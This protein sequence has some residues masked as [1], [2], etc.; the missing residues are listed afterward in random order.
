M[1]LKTMTEHEYRTHPALNQ[2][3]FKDF[4]TKTPKQFAHQQK[5]EVK[6]K[7]KITDAMIL[8]SLTDCLYLE[9]HLLHREFVEIKTVTNDK[10]KTSPAPKTAN[11]SPDTQ[12][13]LRELEAKGLRG[14]LANHKEEA[15][16]IVNA[17]PQA[18]LPA[19]E[20]R[21]IVGIGTICGVPCKG[22]A[23]WIDDDGYL[24]DLK[25]TA[26]FSEFYYKAKAPNSRSYLGYDIQAAWYYTLFKELKP[27]G[28]RWLVVESKEPYDYKIYE[29]SNETLTD[30]QYRIM[31]ALEEYKQCLHENEWPGYDKTPEV[32]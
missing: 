5:P 25:T 26:A 1:A 27:K 16:K 17:L 15:E 10:G 6:A 29:A 28:F 4:I 7:K 21:Q 19:P 20:Q 3:T 30:A 11:N 18:I 32:I 14:Y 23:D 31:D 12:R 8:G 2:S 13:Q 22:K 24:W 9:P